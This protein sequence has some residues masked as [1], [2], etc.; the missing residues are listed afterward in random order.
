MPHDIP[1]F[2]FAGVR[3]KSRILL[4]NYDNVFCFV[5]L[6]S[7]ERKKRQKSS[8]TVNPYPARFANASR[9]TV[10]PHAPRFF[11]KNRLVGSTF[12]K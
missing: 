9:V 2:A 1:R 6:F 3:L 8:R 4:A 12:F 5:S 10:Q 11:S 7:L